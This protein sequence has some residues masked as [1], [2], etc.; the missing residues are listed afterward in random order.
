[1]K[2]KLRTAPVTR[3]FSN[4]KRPSR[5]SGHGPFHRIEFA[6]VPETGDEEAALSGGDHFIDGGIAAGKDE[7]HGSSPIRWGG[8]NRGRWRC[9]RPWRRR[10]NRRRLRW[11]PRSTSKDLFGAAVLNVEGAPCLGARGGVVGDSELPE[12][13]LAHAVVEQEVCPRGR[14]RRKIVEEETERSRDGSGSRITVV[15]ARGES[16]ESN[17]EMGPSR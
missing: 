6:D 14:W 9:R 3:P 11:M 1:L 8:R 2:R 4:G 7:I 13:L 15:T 17:S 16:R 12:E 10:G 5:S